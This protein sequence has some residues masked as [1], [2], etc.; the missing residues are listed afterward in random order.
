MIRPM[1]LSPYRPILDPLPL[2][3]D[4]AALALLLPL[5]L[6]I[7]LVYR[8]LRTT[9]PHKVL[10]ETARLSLFI[11]ALMATAAAALYVLANLL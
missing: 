11:L 10:W 1:P 5:I 2:L 9:T 8:T 6:A 3:G 7:A 4:W